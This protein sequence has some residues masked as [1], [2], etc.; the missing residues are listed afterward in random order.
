MI[1][2]VEKLRKAHSAGKKL[3]F[4]YFWGHTP[5]SD[6][7][8][9]KSCLSQWWM[10]PFQV[11]DVSYT[12]AEQYIMAEKARMFGDNANL[13]RILESEDPHEMKALGRSVSGF[14][15]D[16]WDSRS[17]EIVKR[18]SIAKF[19]QNPLLGSY[20]TSTGRRVLVEASPYDRIW[21]IGMNQAQAEA[22]GPAKWRGSNLLGFALME[23]RDRL[24]ENEGD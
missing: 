22:A 6:G 21:G 11:G 17:Y 2:S 4:L 8:I 9:D 24:N 15:K 19:M 18:G 10:S 16:A 1:Y 7:S 20:L 3:A 5:A 23:A 13:E 14:D 12:C